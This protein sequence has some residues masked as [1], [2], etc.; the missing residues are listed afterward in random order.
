MWAG[1]TTASGSVSIASD[2]SCSADIPTVGRPSPPSFAPLRD[3]S[4]LNRSTASSDGRKTS[5]CRRRERPTLLEHA[6]DLGPHNEPDPAR[7]VGASI[8]LN[9][10]GPELFQPCRVGEVSR[11]QQPDALGPRRGG[12]VRQRQVLAAGVGKTGMNMQVGR[13]LTPLVHPGSLARDSL[14]TNTKEERPPRER[15]SWRC[16]ECGLSGL[17]GPGL[18][19]GI[20]RHPHFPPGVD[21]SL[22]AFTVPWLAT[23]TSRTC[24]PRTPPQQWPPRPVPFRSSLS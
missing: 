18:L 10:A 16:R 11:R 24:S 19:P 14:A 12:Q 22:T 13:E 20:P 17:T 2:V 21:R 7:L 5:T 1:M 8:H 3:S 15:S 4:P 6:A 23:G 9:Q